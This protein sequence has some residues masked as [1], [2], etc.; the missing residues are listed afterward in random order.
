MIYVFSSQWD[1]NPWPF[2]YK[3]NALPLSYASTVYKR[4][5]V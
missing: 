5:Y 1:S 2:A 3:A 4:I